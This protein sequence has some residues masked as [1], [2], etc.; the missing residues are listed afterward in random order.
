MHSITH[1]SKSTY[2]Y[3]ENII[4]DDDN[5]RVKKLGVKAEI[6]N[7]KGLKIQ[8]TEVYFNTSY[9]RC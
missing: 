8:T 3:F 9:K 2:S 7:S 5:S 4:V 1:E 6:V